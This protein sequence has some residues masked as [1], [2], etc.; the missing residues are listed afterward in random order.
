MTLGYPEDNDLI[1]RD[2]DA[3]HIFRHCL[4]TGL[5]TNSDD[6]RPEDV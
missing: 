5:A 6:I 2:G 4:L 1:S 3:C